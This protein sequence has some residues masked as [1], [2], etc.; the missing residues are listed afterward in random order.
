MIGV[1]AYTRCALK[2]ILNQDQVFRIIYNI[3]TDDL[4]SI[5]SPLGLKFGSSVNRREKFVG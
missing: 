4:S 2:Y 3:R 1:T 5:A